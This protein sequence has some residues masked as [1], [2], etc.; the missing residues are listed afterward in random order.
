MNR[1]I[2]FRWKSIDNGEWVYG[3]LADEDYINDIDS[4]DLSSIEVERETVGQFTGLFDKNGIK[5]GLF[6]MLQKMILKMPD[7]IQLLICIQIQK[8]MLKY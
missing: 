7:F 4:I 1:T 3:F 6:S 8:V 2:K 5:V